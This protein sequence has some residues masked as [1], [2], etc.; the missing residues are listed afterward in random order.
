MAALLI[1]TVTLFP[2]PR[3]EPAAFI[4]CIAC[5][6]AWLADVIL[7]VALFLPL[8]ATL[9]AMGLA[10]RRAVITAALFSAAIEL[11][12]LWIPGRDAS[13]G[14]VLSNTLGGWVGVALF[15]TSIRWMHPGERAA[16]RLAVGW[17]VAALTI[18]WLTMLALQPSYPP[19][20]Y[21]GAWTPDLGHL[22]W[23][24]G[25][26]LAAHIGGLSVSPGRAA[27]SDSWRMRLQARDPIVVR[28]TAGPPV[29]D[30]G[31]LFG[32]FDDAQ[33]EIMLVGPD[34]N[35][36]V[37]RFRSWGSALGLDA[38]AY[39]ARALL[40]DIRAG[41]SLR[42]VVTHQDGDV[43]FSV[44][45]RRA[46]VSSPGPEAGWSLLY[47][48]DHLPVWL[49]AVLNAAWLAA[50]AVPVGFWTPGTRTLAALGATLVLGTGWSSAHWG[51]GRPWDAIWMV[52]WLGLGAL[53]S[54]A[55][56]MRRNAQGRP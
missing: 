17:T 14:D 54:H 20:V 8:G 43:C 16:R 18:A 55:R 50:L 27:H 56:P 5:G 33:R 30:L 45:A 41:D 52:A 7:N 26:V 38:R 9:A 21:Y 13:L 42:V 35:D 6:D 22:E 28:A 49:V 46:C 51:A 29:S 3:T 11:A 32:I 31:A 12:Q 53:A 47:S 15:T 48:G 10:P 4:A 1:A 24:R 37:Y 39:R 44:N 2:S 23:Y 36:L 34:R 25:R 19:S 40:R